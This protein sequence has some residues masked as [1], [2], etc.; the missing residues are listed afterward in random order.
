M[1]FFVIA[2][3]IR[4]ILMMFTYHQ[5]LSG[6]VLSTHFF[7][8][9][10][11]TNIYEYLASL[12]ASH[13][14]VRNFGVADIFIYP[15]LS[16]FTLGS[17]L[18]LISFIVPQ[19]FYLDHMNGVVMHNLNPVF[20]LFWLKLPY[21]VVDLLLAFVLTKFFKDQKDKKKV[22]LFW[23]F[24][25]VTLLVTFSMGVFDIIPVLCTLLAALYAKRDRPM[26]AA[27]MLGLGASFKS[28]P[29]FL[30]P[31][32]IV[33]LPG[34]VSKIKASLVGIAP[35]F[36][37]ILPFLAS[38]AFKYMVFGAKSQKMF[39]MIWPVSGAEGLFPYLMLFVLLLLITSRFIPTKKIWK[40]F[41]IYFLILF[42]VTHYHPQWFLW[43]A[44]FLVIEIVYSKL[45]NIYLILGL[46]LCYLAIVV[47]FDRSLSSN[48]LA[49]TFPD[50]EKFA[51]IDK[52]LA[53][54]I[55]LNMLRSSVRS[56]FAGIALFLSYDLL[57]SKREE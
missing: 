19:Q 11:I 1:I 7:A 46:L 53:L 16:Y 2:I 21:L 13:P 47:T 34:I 9:N 14:L 41:L 38:P 25:P 15:P 52:L 30:L 23:M 55:D 8:F 20:N 37:T 44:P 27:F 36:L 12:P 29:L 51:G 45:K 42:S 56:I 31:L 24:N 18:K 28:Y 10:G 49:V 40:S 32:L 17:Y 4:L 5:D 50:I 22:F 39:Y 57:T 43:L 26:L 48:L 54:K 3:V 33:S 35:F 6:Q